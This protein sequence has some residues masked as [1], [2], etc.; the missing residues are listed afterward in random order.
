MSGAVILV[1]G[2]AGYVGSH[3]VVQ[4]L[5]QGYQVVVVDNLVNSSKE[6]LK[7][8]EEISGKEV[9]SYIVD[10]CNREQLD[11]VFRK[12]NFDCVLHFAALKAVGESVAIPLTYYRN[13]IGG[14]VTLLEVMKDHGVKKIVYSSSA[15]VYGTP[16]KLPLTEEHPT[17]IG[18]TN[19]YGRSK[20]F[21]EEILKDL[22]ASDKSWAAISLRYFNPV[23]AHESGRIGE[24]PK[25]I[26]N[27]IMPYIAQVAIGRR[28]D[29]KIFGNDYNT[30]DGTGVRDYVHIHDLAVGHIAAT[31]KILEPNFS[32]F[33]VY[34]LGTGSGFSVLQLVKAFE[35]ASGQKVPYEIVGRRPGDIDASYADASLAKKEL[36]WEAKKNVVDM[37]KDM[38]R[39]QSNNPNGFEDSSKK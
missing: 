2:G 10:L 15:T 34:N 27:N 18:C 8:V 14:T 25:G 3:S 21:V 20:Y 31:E 28:K 33:K 5:L 36:N 7:R 11:E 9:T 29:L 26:P 39:W 35:E 37:C 4:L 22:I 24:D 16:Q 12:H 6:C 23:G 19:P 17:G 32:G 38:W 13:N 1:T 30:P